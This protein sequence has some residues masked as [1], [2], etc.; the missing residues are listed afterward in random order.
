MSVSIGVDE[1]GRGPILGPMVLAAVAVD[2]AGAAE[3][4]SAGV[5]DSKAFGSGA[6][7][8]QRR[9]ALAAEIERRAVWVHTRV[10]HPGEIDA[11]VERGELNH[12]EREMAAA[13]LRRGPV[14]AADRIICDGQRLFSP[15]ARE[16]PGLVAEDRAADPQHA[17]LMFGDQRAKRA[18]ES[19][20]G[21]SRR[22]HS[23][24][25]TARRTPS[26]SRSSSAS[27]SRVAS[28]SPRSVARNS[29]SAVHCVSG[30]SPV[31]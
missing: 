18:L 19:I 27:I 28:E 24:T 25:D 10:A 9:R 26:R 16:F 6:R 20:H 7:A 17:A 11:R 2:E 23:R 29:A 13:A 3:L 14:A 5:A 21:A 31:K 15:L 22:A 1:A 4:A 30:S 12:L 8:K